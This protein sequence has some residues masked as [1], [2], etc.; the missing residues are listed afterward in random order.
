M[1]RLSASCIRQYPRQPGSDFG[2]GG[3]S[4]VR[5]APDDY[6]VPPSSTVLEL[7]LPVDPL[8]GYSAAVRAH[9]G[10]V[11]R[12]IESVP[13]YQTGNAVSEYS[14]VFPSRPYRCR[15]A[16]AVDT[17]SHRDHL[18]LQQSKPAS[19]GP[20]DQ[21]ERVMFYLARLCRR[22]T[23]FCAQAYTAERTSRR[24]RGNSSNH[25]LALCPEGKHPQRFGL[26][27]GGEDLTVRTAVA[28]QGAIS[29]TSIAA[30]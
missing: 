29:A 14:A 5:S 23:R 4:L 13:H 28:G 15:N 8:C 18:A 1:G 20:C 30:R 22:V 27:R 10:I 16:T 24:C 11:R 21:W 3:S 19:A 2:G 9:I 26:C 12:T 25:A 17:T 7:I 6:R